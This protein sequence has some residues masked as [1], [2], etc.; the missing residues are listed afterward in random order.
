VKAKKKATAVIEDPWHDIQHC[1]CCKI[2]ADY[3]IGL[4]WKGDNGEQYTSVSGDFV[5]GKR[6]ATLILSSF[7]GTIGAMHHYGRIDCGH[8]G[9]KVT[10]ETGVHGGYMGKKAPR[11]M[12][13]SLTV[14]RRLSKVEKDM[15]GDPIGRIGDW[16]YR[17]NEEDDV[18]PRA[19]EL[20]KAKFGPGWV[21]VDEYDRKLLCET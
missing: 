9:G 15:N 3:Q 1:K 20:F 10:G 12:H 4:K 18:L 5:E 2:P 21:L 13:L 7:Q 8:V 14:E 11:L 16:T 17:F 19:I 6:V